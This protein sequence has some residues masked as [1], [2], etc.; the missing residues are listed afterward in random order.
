M[1]SKNKPTVEKRIANRNGVRR[2]ILVWLSFL[3]EV[4]FLIWIT[5]IFSN[6]AEWFAVGLRVLALLLVLGIFSQYKTS[7]LKMTWIVLIMG[8]P[9][10]GVT[11]YLM[12]DWSWATRR[13]RARFSKMSEQVLSKLERDEEALAALEKQDKS[14]ANLARYIQEYGGFPLYRDTEVEYHDS[15]EKALE[16]QLLAI[17]EAKRFVFLEYHAFEYAEGFWQLEEALAERVAAGVEVRILYDDVGSIPFITTDFIDRMQERGIL[18]RRFNPASGRGHL[19]MNHRDHRKI[20]VIDGR[21]AF[22]GGYNIANEYFNITHPYGHWKDAG[23]KLTGSAAKSFTALFLEM[24]NI[25][26]GKSENDTDEQM[27][28]YITAGDHP[29]DVFGMLDDK[30]QQQRIEARDAAAVLL[31][32]NFVQPYA[33]SPMDREPLAENVYI[34]MIERA[35]DYIYIS[36]PY[37]ILTDE[38]TRAMSLAAK[39]GVDIRIVTPGIPDKKTVYNVT[40]SYYHGLVR[41][42]VRIF[43]YT[44]GFSHA[45]LFVSDDCVATCGTINL[46]FR[47]LYLH[48]EDGVLLYKGD[49]I[50]KMRADF[51][52]MFAVSEDVTERYATGRSRTLRFGQLVLRMFA[53]LL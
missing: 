31:R 32:E 37:L 38:M 16:E 28:H 35:K 47:G 53:P 13:M 50:E 52:G 46:D 10:M 23:V 41:N 34:G 11:L 15:G 45:K 40:R 27:L 14:V 29:E 18:C 24:W 44:P 30:L 17:A 7:A 26:K 25:T 48:F 1:N 33:D 5:W 36:T 9:V 2:F 43:E 51:E 4:F 19:F 6:S 22:T 42:G 21:V 20:T 8:F 49:V 12:N 3:L 39:R